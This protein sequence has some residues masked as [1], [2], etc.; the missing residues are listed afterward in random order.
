MAMNKSILSLLTGIGMTLISCSKQERKDLEN[1]NADLKNL[2]THIQENVQHKASRVAEFTKDKTRQVKDQLKEKTIEAKEF[3]TEQWEALADKLNG[4]KQRLS[5][6]NRTKIAEINAEF[7]LLRA[8]LNNLQEHL[9]REQEEKQSGEM[10]RSAEL[11]KASLKAFETIEARI[12][13]IKDSF[14]K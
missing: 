11:D 6:A 1:I 5:E 12:K 2:R 13:H 4:W 8:D 7:N 10:E 3:T 9:R 14:D